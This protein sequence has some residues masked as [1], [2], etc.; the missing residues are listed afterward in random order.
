[1]GVHICSPSYSGGW[2]GPGGWGCSKLRPCY[3]SPAWGTEPDPVFKNKKTASSVNIRGSSCTTPPP[4]TGLPRES[5]RPCLFHRT[6]FQDNPRAPADVELFF[7]EVQQTNEELQNLKTSQTLI[8]DSGNNPQW[9]W[10]PLIGWWGI[11]TGHQ[12]LKCTRWSVAEGRKQIFTRQWPTLSM[13]PAGVRPP[14]G[15]KQASHD[16]RMWPSMQNS[17]RGTLLKKAQPDSN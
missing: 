7:E 15:G 10:K 8:N 2:G 13:H 5:S 14:G 12:K 17:P 3:C 4:Q 1:M 9:I 11:I 16:G 6:I